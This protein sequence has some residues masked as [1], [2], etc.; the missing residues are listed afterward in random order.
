MDKKTNNE[1]E[2]GNDV[3]RLL[4]GKQFKAGGISGED[5]EKTVKF[6]GMML[7]SRVEPSPAFK[8][9]LRRRLLLKLAEQEMETERKKE[10]ARTFWE[11]IKRLVPRNP[12]WR[13]VAATVSVVVIALVI[14]W[15]AGVF[16]VQTNQPMLGVP[17]PTSGITQGPVEVKSTASQTSYKLGEQVS[18]T[19]TFE[20][21]SGEPLTLTPFP[22]EVII[23]A[24]SLRPYRTIPG[25][26]SRTLLPG[27]VAEY[28]IT[29][30][31]CDN[32]GQ[33]VPPGDYVVEMLDI[34]L[35]DGKGIAT[36]SDSP[37]IT[38]VPS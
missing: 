12:V 1:K 30:N 29:W 5:Y 27:E 11:A 3:D 2:F 32:E 25:G 26:E 21:K 10:G 8:E 23:A 22:P 33:Q 18:V 19:I 16:P 13:T 38:I 6:A 17:A 7:E 20:N 36:L 31:Q 9:N 35:N 15:R 28:V 34:G 14:V 37:R 4:A 24:T